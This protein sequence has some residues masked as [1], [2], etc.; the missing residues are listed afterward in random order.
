MEVERLIKEAVNGSKSA[1]EDITVAIQDNIY[2]LSLR[3]LA[4]PDNAKDATQDILIKV[5]TNLSS[6][7]FDSH[8]DTWVYRIASNH[9]ISA[10]KVIKRDAG[11]MFDLFKVDLE[12]DL[13][14]P[15]GLKDNPDYQ[16]Q[17]NELRISCTMAMLLCLNL[18]HRMAYILGD[19]LEMAHDE[20]S[21]ILSISKSNFRQQ[22]SRARAKVIEFTNKSCGL[23][24]ECANC[25]CEKKLTGAIKRQRVNPLKLNL[26]AES[27]SS[28][29]E[30]KEI[31]LQTQQELKTLVLQKSVNQYKCPNELSNIIGLLMEQGVKA[32]KTH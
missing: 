6:F 10:N 1:L 19:I 24:N 20:A 30:V 9:L 3:M 23:L 14:E 22:L 7:R 26:Q 29:M 32:N 16:A 17:L 11:L 2:Y 27:D 8:F 13:Q 12:Q 4:N 31:L 18:P 5:I 25:S 15:V 21:T 28:Y